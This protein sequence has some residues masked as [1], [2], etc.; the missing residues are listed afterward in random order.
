MGTT[1]CLEHPKYLQQSV[2]GNRYSFR[3][4]REIKMQNEP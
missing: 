4:G 1:L 2:V 3:Q